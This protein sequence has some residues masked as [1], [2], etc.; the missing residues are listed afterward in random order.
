[1][2]EPT[3][4]DLSPI[5]E[6]VHAGRL[7]DALRFIQA[8]REKA[9][10]HA[11]LWMNN[12]QILGAL[13]RTGDAVT[14]LRSAQSLFPFE[15]SIGAFLAR[16]LKEPP[17]ARICASQAIADYPGS[18]EVFQRGG[19]GMGTK[20]P[21]DTYRL[22]NAS[23][24]APM[25]IA[26][27][28]DCAAIDQSFVSRPI[29]HMIA[30]V[31]LDRVAISS[32][33]R[34]SG[35][36]LVLYGTWSDGFYHWMME[37]IPRYLIA[38]ALGFKGNIA[39]AEP[40]PFQIDSLKALGVSPERI[41]VLPHYFWKP[42]VLWLPDRMESS[43]LGSFPNL[44]DEMRTRILESVRN[45]PTK[46]AERLYVPRRNPNRPRRIVNEQQLHTLVE[47]YGFQECVLENLSFKEQISAAA[48]CRAIIGPHGAGMV[49][50]LFMPQESLVVEFFAPTYVNPSVVQIAERLEHRYHMIVS[51]HSSG[52]YPYGQDIEVPIQVV[53]GTLRHE[54]G[55]H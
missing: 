55:E 24:L 49:H 10:A 34:V 4:A 23:V 5:S 35:E 13:G 30:E 40:L 44:I 7:E 45:S 52:E 43:E 3:E 26:F 18:G 41:H 53:N 19:L 37:W 20:R 1:M 25:G 39:L 46:F 38:E 8:L 17:V 12:A 27:T 48:Q 14:L 16:I 2:Y 21:L 6:A 11:Y 22:H 29:E 15:A 42:E 28:P 50:S 32:A 9:P 31:H 51:Y 36:W 54:L 33:P 47:F